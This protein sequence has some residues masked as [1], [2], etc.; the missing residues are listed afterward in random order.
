[1]R[2][3]RI[4][5]VDS[6]FL[7]QD[8]FREKVIAHLKIWLKKQQNVELLIVSGQYGINYYKKELK[9][10]PDQIYFKKIPFSSK[11]D[12]L[13]TLKLISEFIQRSLGS[14]FINLADQIDIVY[15]VSGL[16][17]DVWVGSIL[18]CKSQKSKFFVTFD[19]FVPSPNKRPGN[20]FY[21]FIPFFAAILSI[22]LL[23]KAD[24]V[25]AYM[26]P[27]NV[28]KL[29][30][31][32]P[33]MQHKIFRFKNGLD[34]DLLNSNLNISIKKYDLSYLGR[35]HKAKGI[36]D[37]IEVVRLLKVSRANIKAAII[38][39][40]AFDI[41][42]NVNFLI[43]KY[44]LEKNIHF[45]GYVSTQEKYKIL[46]QSKIFLFLSYDE[47]YPVALLEAISV[48]IPSV[49]YALKCYEYEPFS[50]AKLH[51]I[52][53]GAIT[54]VF[55]KCSNLL[56][57]KMIAKSF[58]KNYSKIQGNEKVFPS[59]AY[60]AQKEFYFFKKSIK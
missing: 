60:N 37:F 46:K 48:G 31:M 9:E 36:F 29:N 19:N 8:Q 5:V 30:E 34:Y 27:Y 21:N 50:I 18:N 13:T 3:F 22:Y 40:P 33:K 45:F 26:N 56:N 58:I 28:D 32:L 11:H 7:T 10:Y 6:T 4:L 24:F 15:T 53:L 54:K 51:K 49:V 23:R 20:Y 55:K 41:M 43:K 57:D 1:M 44:S 14:F 39:P 38:G 35:I 47:S 42:T 52:E 2:K 59:Y 16:F 17:L 12:K 25:F